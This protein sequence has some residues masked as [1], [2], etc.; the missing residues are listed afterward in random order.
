MVRGLQAAASGAPTVAGEPQED[1]RETGE[2]HMRQAAKTQ[3][4]PCGTLVQTS[5]R[6]PFSWA[7]TV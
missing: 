5:S 1:G 2:A 7:E 6:S 3:A 4:G